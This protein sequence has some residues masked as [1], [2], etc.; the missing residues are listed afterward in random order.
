[1]CVLPGP[2]NDMYVAL[3]PVS[4][5]A[6][7]VVNL[8][9]MYRCVLALCQLAGQRCD[10]RSLGTVAVVNKYFIAAQLGAEVIDVY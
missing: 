8:M 10:G 5:I 7:S 2:G 1:M 6:W 3:K 9:Y 4:V